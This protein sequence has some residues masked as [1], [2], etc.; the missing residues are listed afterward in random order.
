MNLNSEER[1]ALETLI[2]IDKSGKNVG[3]HINDHL[4]SLTDYGTTASDGLLSASIYTIEGPDFKHQCSIY[5]SLAQKGALIAF[6]R[7]G[8]MEY[9]DLTSDGRNYFEMEEE[10]KKKERKKKWSERRFS[11]FMAFLSFVFS[12]LTSL[13]LSFGVPC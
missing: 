1:Q 6:G 10:A 2:E 11:I 9:Y 12:V 7:P 4:R 3:E 5:E 8:S 13:L